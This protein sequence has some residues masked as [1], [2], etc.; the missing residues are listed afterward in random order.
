M[1]RQALR[2]STHL[3]ALDLSGMVSGCVC[4]GVSLMYSCSLGADSVG[5]HTVL[6]S[7]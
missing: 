5:A 3:T 1:L 7:L 6:T 2:V 4:V